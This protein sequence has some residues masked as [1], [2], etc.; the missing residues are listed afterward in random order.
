MGTIFISEVWA[1]INQTFRIKYN[2]N[3]LILRRN[4]YFNNKC[5]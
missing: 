4:F 2:Y 3:R 1:F 5:N